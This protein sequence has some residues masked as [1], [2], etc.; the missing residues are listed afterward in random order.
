MTNA[1]DALNVMTGAKV[2]CTTMRL[3]FH[4]VEYC[5]CSFEHKSKSNINI[6]KFA[7][8]DNIRLDGIIYGC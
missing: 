3:I 4:L 6:Y 2:F 5:Q 7:G 1:R 8:I